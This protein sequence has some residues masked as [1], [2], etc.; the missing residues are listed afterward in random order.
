MRERGPAIGL[1]VFN[2]GKGN[3]KREKRKGGGDPPLHTVAAQEKREAERGV[4]GREGRR[5]EGRT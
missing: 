5:Q 2:Y 3:G 4:Q 1:P